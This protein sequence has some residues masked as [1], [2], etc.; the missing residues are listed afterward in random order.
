[1]PAGGQTGALASA[2]FP[3]MPLPFHSASEAA[4][5][6]IAE[7]LR[8][9]IPLVKSLYEQSKCANWQISVEQFVTILARSAASR[10]KPG[11]P[12]AD[13]LESYL[14]L[15]HLQDLVLATACAQGNES[16]WEC[17]FQNFRSYLHSSAAAILK[18]SADSPEACELADALFADLY[19][20]NQDKPGRGSLLNYFHGRSKLST[21]LRTVLAQ[22]HI[23]AIR[24]GKRWESLDEV[25]QDGH[26]LQET[27]PATG[28]LT[29]PD[30]HRDQYL[31]LLSAALTQAIRSLDKYERLRLTEYYLQERTLASI[32]RALGEHEATVSRKLD[33]TRTELR[34]EVEK[35]LRSGSLQLNGTGLIAG[36]LDDAQIAL[37]FEYALEDWPLDWAKVFEDKAQTKPAP[38]SVQSPI[39][40]SMPENL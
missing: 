1:M 19:G 24:V 33:R 27:V 28:P 14:S 40:K 7:Q 9:Q 36:G 13:E 3:Q 21:W 26:A 17:F 34:T 38:K 37:C 18:R 5:Q 39:S 11:M 29:S 22:R 12:S 10:F 15:L 20:M 25:D 31:A 8:A 6:A 30:P 32:G 16:A 2:Y 4:L 35:I 23:D